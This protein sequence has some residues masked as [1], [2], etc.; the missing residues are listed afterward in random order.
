MQVETSG[1]NWV[2][3]FLYSLQVPLAFSHRVFFLVR[4][5]KSLLLKAL[6][7][8]GGDYAALPKPYSHIVTWLFGGPRTAP[9]HFSFS[10][11]SPSPNH[12]I[13]QQPDESQD[14]TAH[15]RWVSQSFSGTCWHKMK[16]RQ[17]RGDVSLGLQQ[18]HF[19]ASRS[20]CVIG[21]NDADTQ[22]QR[23]KTALVMIQSVS[24]G[25]C[26]PSNKALISPSLTWVGFLSL[27]IKRT[28]ITRT[29]LGP[30]HAPLSP[31]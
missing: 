5:P 3:L 13:K 7:F 24:W 29:S 9:P 12:W 31:H 23:Q 26:I 27:A 28:M 15:S 19:L 8:D 10:S 11:V 17:S 16:G 4:W 18:S 25:L 14:R 2:S 21:E 20:Q 30:T 1:L 6:G 22:K